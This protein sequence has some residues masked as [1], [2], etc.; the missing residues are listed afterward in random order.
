MRFR[1][2]RSVRSSRVAPVALFVLAAG[3][4]GTSAPDASAEAGSDAAHDAVR[5]AGS[6][7]SSA[8]GPCAD[9]AGDALFPRGEFSPEAYLA[10]ASRLA[11]DEGISLRFGRDARCYHPGGAP[12]APTVAPRD[13]SMP[14]DDGD[15]AH[16]DYSQTEGQVAFLADDPTD[17][18]VD[19][20]NSLLMGQGRFVTGPMPS[21]NLAGLITDFAVGPA[22]SRNRL[23]VALNGGPIVAPL[24][25][26]RG[27]SNEGWNQGALMVFQSGL[28]A[29]SGTVTGQ[30]WVYTR[31]PAHKVPTGVAVTPHN[32]FALVTVWDTLTRQ[33]ELA[34][35]ALSAGGDFWGDWRASYPG[36]F[37]FGVFSSLKVLGYVPLP[38]MRAPT[39]I[40]V[41]TDVNIG[42]LESIEG[43]RADTHAAGWT[44]DNPALRASFASGTNRAN[45]T[46]AGFAVIASRSERKVAFVDLQPLFDAFN[47]MYFGTPEDY[48]RTR[49]QGPAPTQ[50]PYTFESA[51]T[52]M[53]TVL[54]VRELAQRPSAVAASFVG[55]ARAQAYVATEDGELSLYDVGA[56]AT[57]SEAHEGDVTRVGSVRVGNNPTSIALPKAHEYTDPMFPRAEFIVVSRGDAEV[58]WV[59][60][61]GASAS[62]LRTLR[63]ARMTDPIAVEDSDNHGT[64]SY[65]LLVADYAGRQMLGYRYGPV[66]FH[67]NGG[68]RW[69]MGTDGRAPYEF[70]RSFR[71]GGRPFAI[72]LQNTP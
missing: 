28:I 35:V 45:H 71:I 36:L 60:V 25:V 20:F 51:P 43:G 44:L 13:P 54:S 56:L 58:S 67:T 57:A 70:T 16:D 2:L 38:G 10:L 48:A 61:D 47:R 39:Q 50:W 19:H 69:D 3:C 18:A 41:S 46:H 72:S 21:P 26:A 4:T 53:P 31:L 52:S 34:V 6:D 32:E 63:D 12:T 1:T 22:N 59:H 37:N 11:S 40:A 49:E 30:T 27:Q 7:A 65:V 33:G 23:G 24:A 64:E 17:G 15:R 9:P 14:L 62:V 5:E 29:S 8:L 66:I 68:A 42:W 55:A